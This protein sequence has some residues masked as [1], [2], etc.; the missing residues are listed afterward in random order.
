MNGRI[1]FS[2]TDNTYGNELF[3]L[4]TATTLPLFSE[5]F[6]ATL[7]Q[8]YA[9]LSWLVA[10]DRQLSHF[11]V[12]RSVNGKAFDVL[13]SLTSRASGRSAYTYLDKSVQ[14]LS[15]DVVYYRLKRYKQNGAVSYSEIV[16]L[17]LP[18]KETFL[19]YPNPARAQVTIAFNAGFNEEVTLE[20]IDLSGAILSSQKL[21]WFKGLNTHQVDLNNYPAGIYLIRLKG[22]NVNKTIKLQ[23]LR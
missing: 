3:V 2:A 19:A 10:D 8:N 22:Q 11:D 21:I 1:I 5:R 12:E 23:H 9:R 20:L 17:K 16:R 7:E 15:N 13:S 6:S 18:T 4:N 14:V